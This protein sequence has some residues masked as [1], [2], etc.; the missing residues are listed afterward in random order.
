MDL[1]VLDPDLP[2]SALGRVGDDAEGQFI[3]LDALDKE[4]GVYEAVPSL[5]LP[6]G[7][8]KGAVGAGDAFCAGTLCGAYKGKSLREGI[9]LGITAMAC[10]LSEPGAAGDIQEDGVIT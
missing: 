2:L 9:E 1:A 3:L 6:W 10:S 7:Y 4:D 5:V 8:I